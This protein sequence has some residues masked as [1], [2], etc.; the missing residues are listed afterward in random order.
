MNIMKEI[1]NNYRFIVFFF[2]LSV[3]FTSCT[4]EE[5]FF[6]E[7]IPST[8][9]VDMNTYDY[10]ASKPAQFE[11][12]VKIIDSTNS[13]DL[14]NSQDYTVLAPQNGSIERYI[15]EN[16]K[17]EIGDFE[18][19]ELDSL[20]NQYLF[21]QKITSDLA[22]ADKFETFNLNDNQIEFS[23]EGE[24]WKGVPSV[25][26]NYLSVLNMKDVEDDKDDVL[27]KVVTPDMVTTTGI[28]HILSLDHLFGF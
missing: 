13:E 4:E 15:L 8:K 28:V 23:I 21:V 10:L 24:T 2:V 11:Q 22:A 17:M 18:T 3:F 19:I 16:G 9:N 25:G 12:F 6:T 1:N 26:A 20:L 7:N 14:I 27:V 5:Y